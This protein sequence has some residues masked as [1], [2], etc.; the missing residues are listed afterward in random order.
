MEVT[1]LEK[2]GSCPWSWVP[3]LEITAAAASAGIKHYKNKH[4][5]AG[6]F[7]K[8]VVSLVLKEL[9]T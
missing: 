8:K 4:R 3:V 6:K 2:R 9:I 7:K 1:S 5:D